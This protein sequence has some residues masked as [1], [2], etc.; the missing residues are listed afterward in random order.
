MEHLREL[1]SLLSEVPLDLG[2]QLTQGATRL[3]QG[4]AKTTSQLPK[5][6]GTLN[7]VRL[8]HTIEIRGGDELRV[9]RE[10]D[11]LRQV[12]PMHLLS[13]IPGDQRNGRLHFGHDP[14]GFVDAIETAL[15][16]VCVLSSGAHPCDVSA[17][18]G[19]DQLA[20]ATHATIEVDKVLGLTD[21]LKALF[22]LLALLGQSRVLTAGRV[23]GVL[24]LF[25]AHGRFWRTARSALF[26]LISWA[27]KTGLGLI[28]LLLGFAERLVRGSLFG[29]QRRTNGCAECMLN[30][31]QIG[32]VMRA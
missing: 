15:A 24:G 21:G 7:G 27:L 8:G 32:G 14:R 6:L 22:D 2:T 4:C 5:R 11:G 3:E 19:G 31:Q 9:H 26:K 10:G 23:E 12:P 13:H 30:M 1:V 20:V 17:D 25:K 29:G 16:Q 28:E 18:I